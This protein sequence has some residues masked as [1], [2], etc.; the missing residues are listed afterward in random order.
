MRP[1]SASARRLAAR[2]A[3]LLL[4]AWSAGPAASQQTLYKWIDAEGR[5]QYSDKPPKGFAGEVTRIETDAQP[6][7]APP[8][9]KPAPP[10]ADA[11]KGARPVEDSLARRRATRARL[12]ARL[13]LARANRDA[14]KKALDEANATAPDVEERQVI[15]QRV[16][17]GTAMVGAQALANKDATQGVA[18]GGGMHGMTV[19]S[20]CR[21]AIDSAGRKATICPTMVPGTA[22]FDRIA[23][24]EEALRQ[25]EEALAAAEEAWRRGVD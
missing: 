11:E 14:A 25:A 8:V 3:V 19:R 10:K 16:K 6:P 15:Q 22:Y 9:V 18:T 4:A 1:S 17:G 13:E 2:L 5:Q 24:L 23:K 12:E 21:Q 7:V 20:N